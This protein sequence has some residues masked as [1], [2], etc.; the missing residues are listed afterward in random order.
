MNGN[1][2]KDQIWMQEQWLGIQMCYFKY[3]QTHIFMQEQMKDGKTLE[4]SMH[5][6]RDRLLYIGQ[7]IF[8]LI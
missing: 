5:K 4:V 2:T 1:K 7:Y 8:I 6:E 3:S